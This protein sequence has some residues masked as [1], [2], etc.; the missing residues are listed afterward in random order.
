MPARGGAGTGRSAWAK[1]TL[2][3]GPVGFTLIEVLVVI[4][5]VALVTGV[6]IPSFVS[7]FREKGEST[8]RKLAVTMGEA[9]DRAMLTD[10]LVRLK[11]DLDKQTL[12][13]EEAPSSYLVAKQA[14]RPPSD[15]ERED[16]DKKEAA[17]FQPATELMKDPMQLNESLKLVQLKSPRYKTPLKEGTGYVYFF[18]NGSTDGATLFF[19]TNDKVKEAITVHPITGQSKIEGKGPDDK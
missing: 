7:A 1:S 15:R 8:A 11:A 9:R 19:E 14:D 6:F 12:T 4:G 10:K 5:L 16:Q 13:F 3:R 17:T 18:N 2:L